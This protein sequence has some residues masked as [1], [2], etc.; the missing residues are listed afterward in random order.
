MSIDRLLETNREEILR[1]AARHGAYNIRVFG[2][3]A[4]VKYV[5]TVTW[6][7]W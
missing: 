5:P 6:I 4:V 1:I 3:R 7:C 2:L